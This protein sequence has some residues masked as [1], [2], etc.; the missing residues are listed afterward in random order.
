LMKMTFLIRANVV[1][2]AWVIRRSDCRLELQ[3][4]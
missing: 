1:V 2:F 4:E 3:G